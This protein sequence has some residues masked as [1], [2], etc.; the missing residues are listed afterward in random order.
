MLGITLEL[1]IS[2]K[3]MCSSESLKRHFY[4]AVKTDKTRKKSSSKYCKRS[5]L[6]LLA[7]TSGLAVIKVQLCQ[8][9]VPPSLSP[10]DSDC[11]IPSYPVPV[12]SSHLS[13][14]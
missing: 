3:L 11:G 14:S 2:Q 9:C 13:P 5:S 4:L 12:P 1:E 7:L 6:L 8:A 10:D